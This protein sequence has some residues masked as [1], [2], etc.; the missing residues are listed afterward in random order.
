[1]NKGDRLSFFRTLRAFALDMDGTF[2][3][4]DKP[5]PG[6][7]RF[8]QAL[9]A[10]KIPFS[11]LTNNS[12]RGRAEYA[13]KLAAM[14]VQ[15]QDL[16]IYTAGD[17]TI[18]YL[19]AEYPDQRI[20]LLGT[21]SLKEQFVQEGLCLDEQDPQV[22]V[23]AYDTELTYDALARFCLHLR[24]G[25][26]YIATHPDI[27]CPTPQGPIPDIGAMMALIASS[28]GRE[29]QAVIGKPNAQIVLQLARSWGLP[30]NAL[31]MIGD[32]LYTDIALG[33]SAGVG[34]I[35]VLSG[36]TQ[37]SDLLGSPFCP[38]CVCRD[39]GEVCDC[40]EEALPLD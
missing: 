35:L 20:E 19:K 25:L 28:T 27:N 14:G 4:G 23:L 7:L 1:M 39:L 3:L 15:E 37:S 24:L 32:R 38:D 30:A 31:C 34:T 33:Q 21:A 26:P 10:R 5:L 40:L 9:N 12:S 16:R 18:A 13:H 6:A 8:L 36:E 11:F 17:A 22:L 2:F 29:A